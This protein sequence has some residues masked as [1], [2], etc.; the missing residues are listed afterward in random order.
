MDEPAPPSS[1]ASFHEWLLQRR[2]R[3]QRESSRDFRPPRPSSTGPHAPS[4][5]PERSLDD[6]PPRLR[7]SPGLPHSTPSSL[8]SLPCRGVSA[9][10]RRTKKMTAADQTVL[11]LGTPVEHV[12]N[13]NFIRQH[14]FSK[15]IKV[16][17]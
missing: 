17:L 6:Y 8:S 11:D 1:P 3:D 14:F 7:T 5:Q 2:P 4:C 9:K 12:S 15:L 16:G 10:N 13:S